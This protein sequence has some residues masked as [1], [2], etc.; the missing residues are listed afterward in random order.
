MNED[1][2]IG[3]AI[4]VFII[5]I[6][7]FGFWIGKFSESIKYNSFA[8]DEYLRGYSEGITYRDKVEC[9]NEY[10]YKPLNEVNAH[11]LKY[12]KKINK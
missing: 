7:T 5:S 8:S 12:Y 10:D 11:C 6:F 2:K 3:I 1:M 4:T 9:Q